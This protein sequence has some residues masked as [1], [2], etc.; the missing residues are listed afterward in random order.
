MWGKNM[1]I[2][3]GEIK[4]KKIFKNKYYEMWQYN[5]KLSY[6]KN[7]KNSFKNIEFPKQNK[8]ILLAPNWLIYEDQA[9]PLLMKKSLLITLNTRIVWQFTHI[10]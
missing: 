1:L 5:T 10:L 9:K 4:L 3:G 8:Q 2:H 6:R 7:K